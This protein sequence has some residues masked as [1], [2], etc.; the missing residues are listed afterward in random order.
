MWV[1]SPVLMCSFTV[2]RGGGGRGDAPPE[3]KLAKWCY[4]GYRK[5]VITDLKST[6]LKI[7]NVQKTYLAQFSLR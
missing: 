5:C 7:I 1:G 3:K 2:A 6:I 4:L